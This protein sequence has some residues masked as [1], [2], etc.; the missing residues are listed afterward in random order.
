MPGSLMPEPN[1][2]LLVEDDETAR[3]AFR[4]MLICEGFDVE[5]VGSAEDAIAEIS[6]WKPAAVLLDLH[7]PLMNGL[8]CLRNFRSQQSNVPVAL[9]TGDYFLDESVAR[10]FS[11][12]GAEI[13]FKPVW[14]AD[15]MRIVKRLL[16][17]NT[18]APAS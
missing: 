5:A 14:E 3:E 7:L 11:E 10:E 15:L 8:E 16:A 9:L 4:M 13:Y 12:L 17:R 2:I 18:T 1:P 6:R